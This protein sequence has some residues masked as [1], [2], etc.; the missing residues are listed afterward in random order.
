MSVEV[1]GSDDK[2]LPTDQDETVRKV[3]DELLEMGLLE[4]DDAITSTNGRYVRRGQIIYDHNRKSA[5]QIVNAFL[6]N[7]GVVRV[8]RYAEWKYMMTHDCVLKAKHE[9]EKMESK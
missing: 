5:L 2:P 6:D 4:N 7:M 1:C 8:G 3:K 9:A